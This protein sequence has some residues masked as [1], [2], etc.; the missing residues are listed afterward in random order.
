MSP[1]PLAAVDD[2]DDS[3]DTSTWRSWYT[4]ADRDGYG[5]PDTALSVLACSLPGGY[6]SDNTDCDDGA[7]AVYPFVI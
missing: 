1:Y 6:T 5:D 2:D 7:A 3:L 4:D